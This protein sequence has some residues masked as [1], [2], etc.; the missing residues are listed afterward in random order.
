M[1]LSAE[2]FNRL[3]SKSGY[4]TN[5]KGRPVIDISLFA[6][7]GDVNMNINRRVLNASKVKDAEGNVLADSK[8]E[9]R[10]KGEMDDAG[11]RYD[12]QRSFE[13]LPTL[14]AENFGTLRR[15]KWSPDFTFEEQDLPWERQRSLLHYWIS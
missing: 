4:K 1:K 12:F 7:A 11:L 13:L 5:A 9:Y 8:W 6:D 15:R 3:F 2:E 14:R 10:C